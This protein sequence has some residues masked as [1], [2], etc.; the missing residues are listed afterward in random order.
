MTVVQVHTRTWRGLEGAWGH[1]GAD[2]L[3][4]EEM[5]RAEV[6]HLAGPDGVTEVRA[7]LGAVNEVW[8]ASPRRLRWGAIF[9]D[10]TSI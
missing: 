6:W 4:D 5:L 1:R 3:S 2:E 7:V 8:T 10:E 9:A